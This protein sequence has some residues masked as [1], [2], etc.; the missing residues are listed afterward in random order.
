MHGV[1]DVAPLVLLC[2]PAAQDTQVRSA[3]AFGA[4]SSCCPGKHVVTA[5]HDVWPALG[6]CVSVL[7]GVHDVASF[8]LLCVPAAQHT[9]VRSAVA[10]GAVSSCCPGKHVITAQHDVWPALG[11]C[12][13]AALHGV[14]DVAPPA[15]LPVPAGQGRHAALLLIPPALAP[16]MP[17][18]Q[19]VHAARPSSG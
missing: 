16:N 18:A 4:V 12:V 9:Q 15:P 13:S 19:S 6:W 3:V 7:H 8:V 10:F 5:W 14:H 2:V 11:W 1:Q 17:S